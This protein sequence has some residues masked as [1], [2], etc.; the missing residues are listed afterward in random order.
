MADEK[1]YT[2]FARFENDPYGPIIERI[3]EVP[4]DEADRWMVRAI[5]DGGT[6]DWTVARYRCPEDCFEGCYDRENWEADHPDQDY[7]Y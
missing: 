3:R 2:A 6:V 4:W 5:E 7:P 1:L